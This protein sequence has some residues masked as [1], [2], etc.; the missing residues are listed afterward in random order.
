[1]GKCHKT[2]PLHRAPADPWHWLLPLTRPAAPASCSCL[3][4]PQRHYYLP[5]LPTPMPWLNN[6]ESQLGEGSDIANTSPP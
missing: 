1:M 2:I 5:T 6:H 3:P 4:P